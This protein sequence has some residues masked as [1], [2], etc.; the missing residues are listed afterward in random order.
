MAWRQATWDGTHWRDE[1][2]CRDVD[3]RLFFAVGSGPEALEQL[4][5]A[6]AVCGECPVAQECL[7]FAVTTN[8]EYGVWGGLDEE[9]RREVRRQWRRASRRSS[10][11][12]A[13]QGP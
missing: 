11:G 6:K 10:E 2:A 1:A 9:E 8:Q 12:V 7:I 4:A 5:L 13:V 3:P